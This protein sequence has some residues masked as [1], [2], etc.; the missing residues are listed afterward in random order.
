LENR[1]YSPETTLKKA[2]FPCSEEKRRGDE[3][4]DTDMGTRDWEGVRAAFGM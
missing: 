3:G 1:S 2:L 4:R